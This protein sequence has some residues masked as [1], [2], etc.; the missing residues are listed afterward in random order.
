MAH[1]ARFEKGQS[2]K[3]Q[4]V[5]VTGVFD[6]KGKG[7]TGKNVSFSISNDL[8]DPKDLD[9]VKTSPMLVYEQYKGQDGKEKT[10]YSASYSQ[11]QWEK[12]EAAANKDGDKLVVIADLFPNRNG[13][14]K[15]LMVNTNTLKTPDQPFNAEAHRE[16]TLNARKEREAKR[17]ADKGQDAPVDE[18]AATQEAPE[19]RQ[20]EMEL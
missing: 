7:M 20:E 16:N 10:S 12:I 17:D 2:M 18:A 8:A 5:H 19:S 3:G 14:T 11:S 13:K 4:R 9:N 6:Q 15:G 1:M